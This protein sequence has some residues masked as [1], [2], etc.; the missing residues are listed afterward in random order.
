MN[1]NAKTVKSIVKLKEELG[2][3]TEEVK[4]DIE[5]G[6]NELTSIVRKKRN[7]MVTLLMEKNKDQY[8]QI[9]DVVELNR[10]YLDM[11]ADPTTGQSSVLKRMTKVDEKS[12]I[13]FE[14]FVDVLK[15][16][17]LRISTKVLKHIVDKLTVYSWRLDTV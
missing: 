16:F 14:G 12:L 9:R 1:R 15:S 10:V 11:D 8:R 17:E 4:A 3:I 7:L 6:M 2:P 13:T 5:Q